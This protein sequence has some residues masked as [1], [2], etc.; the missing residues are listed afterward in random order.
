LVSEIEL[1]KYK[2]LSELDHG[3]ATQKGHQ[4]DDLYQAKAGH[5]RPEAWT[6]EGGTTTLT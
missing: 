2:K 1:K 4:R 6:V 3:S 5:V